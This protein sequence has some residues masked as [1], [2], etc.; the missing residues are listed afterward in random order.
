LVACGLVLMSESLNAS[1]AEII[2]GF[3]LGPAHPYAGLV[4]G[5]N[6]AFFGTTI[7]GGSGD[8]GTVFQITTNGGLT[9]VGSFT[10]ANGAGPYAGMVMG[11]DGNFYGTTT[12]GGSN[13]AGTVFRL[14]ANG[15]LS[16]L[17][18]FDRT[19]G[20]NPQ[21]SLVFDGGGNLYGT[22]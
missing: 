16:T 19:N 14:T 13:S 7:R 20:A 1:E 12:F 11:S 3:Q 5:S 4:E 10:S 22:T 18:S 8:G 15:V 17:V 6:G 21:S 9:T 2:H